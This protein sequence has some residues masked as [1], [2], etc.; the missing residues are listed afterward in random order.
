MGGLRGAAC[1]FLC[2][3]A[4]RKPPGPPRR[5]VGPRR[6][7]QEQGWPACGAMPRFVAGAAVNWGLRRA[8]NYCFGCWVPSPRVPPESPRDEGGVGPHPASVWGHWGH[9]LPSSR[10]PA[11]SLAP[12]ERSCRVRPRL[13]GDKAGTERAPGHEHAA[14]RALAEQF[15]YQIGVRV[16]PSLGT[17]AGSW[18]AR[19][20]PGIFTC[21]SERKIHS[22]GI[23]SKLPTC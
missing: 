22:E 23:C 18:R 2:S 19:S 3:G 21:G 6:A 9:P 14:G 15:V 12:S 4:I 10:A 7:Q 13:G 16:G 11:P 17:S 8:A 1:G 20:E 5:G